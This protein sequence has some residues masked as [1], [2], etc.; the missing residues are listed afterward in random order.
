MVRLIFL[1]G[2]FNMYSR[3]G[4]VKINAGVSFS[5]LLG[6][7]LRLSSHFRAFRN[8]PEIIGTFRLSRKKVWIITL[9]AT[10]SVLFYGYSLI[11][12]PSFTFFFF[13]KKKQKT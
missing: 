13:E 5:C 6:V 7:I 10:F 1:A 3:R 9:S 12:M 4:S 2:F 11:A 8:L